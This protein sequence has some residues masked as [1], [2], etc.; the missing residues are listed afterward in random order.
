MSFQVFRDDLVTLGQAERIHNLA[1]K[2]LAEVGFEILPEPI[3]ER[4]RA[5]GFRTA[6]ARV[7]F[8]PHVVEEYVSEMR[9]RLAQRPARA[10]DES[11]RLTLSVSA[12]PHHL[13]DV[14]SG[15]IVPYT[16]EN[17]ATMTRF[18]DTFAEEGVYGAAPGYPFDV[19]APLQPVL[20][21]RIAA[22]NARNGAYPVDP[23][24]ALTAN[25]IFE[26]AE[27]MGHPI[28]GLPVYL[29]TPLRLGGESLDIVMQNLHR[30]RHISVSSMPAV[31]ATTPIRPLSAFVLAAAEL[32]GGMVIMRTL[33]GL[34]V[35]FFVSIFP[36]D[37][38]SLAMV[39]GSPENFLFQ[40]AERDLNR[41]YGHSE[42]RGA[43]NLHCMAKLPG[44][45]AA[46]E[47]AAMMTAGALLGAR[48]F[49]GAGAL[50]LD[51]VFSPEDLLLNCEIR[52]W[53]QR[54]MVGLDTTEPDESVLAEIQAGLAQGFVGQDATLD[55]YRELYWYPR[56]FERDFLGPWLQAGAQ[57]FPQRARAEID[58]RLASHSYELDP[59]RR[60]EMAR[61]ARAAEAAVQSV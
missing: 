47:K 22:E 25:F 57:S 4:V 29:P 38:H 30:L 43:G 17:L 53:V 6:G 58:R 10:S 23:T 44:P 52:E 40:L 18:V 33:T 51:E 11:R 8:E 2:V 5:A 36:F 9:Q 15:Q 20:Q 46:A 42:A 61:L 59:L 56:L 54:L 45:Q 31:G 55:H 49:T 48:H 35:S 24:S 41:F 37:L 39:F 32:M 21:Y 1:L 60:R 28:D 14:E 12:Y 26:M 13:H 50:S 16:V 19:P 3:L 34:P 27:V 7:F